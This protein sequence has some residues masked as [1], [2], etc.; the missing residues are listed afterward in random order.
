MAQLVLRSGFLDKVKRI[1]GITSDAALANAIGVS[2]R[3]ITRVKSDPTV[4][5]SD[6]IAGLCIAFGYSP[7]DVVEAREI[8]SRTAVPA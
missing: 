4:I 5:Q 3:T 6:M 2:H 1:H 8:T 7:S